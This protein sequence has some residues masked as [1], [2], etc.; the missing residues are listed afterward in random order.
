MADYEVHTNHVR[1]VEPLTRSTSRM[2]RTW[3]FG[4][5]ISTGEHSDEPA[6]EAVRENT[7]P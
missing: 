6:L 5:R 1:L 3:I 7:T 2:N 4:E